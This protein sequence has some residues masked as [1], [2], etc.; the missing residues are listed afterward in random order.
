L[1]LIYKSPSF[2]HA[3]LKILHGSSLKKRYELIAR[4]IGEKK[5]VFE[6]GCGT[7]LI[8]PY[9]QAGCVYE[10][11]DLNEHFINYNTKR[12]RRV[13]QKNMFDF[14][15]YPPNDVILLCDILHHVVPRHEELIR[16]V[17]KKTKKLIISEP[18]TSFKLLK[19]FKRTAYFLHK[20]LLDDDGINPFDNM[21]EWD[22]PEEKLRSLFN[23]CGCTKII[24]MGWNLV[25]VF[26]ENQHHLITKAIG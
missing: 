14:N 26:D 23:A 17:V 16:M 22:Y 6:P 11:W 12:G 1:S 25:A 18:P 24:K 10:G 4:E 2:Y 19:K 20:T 7:C 3:F 15:D 8:Y 9:L 13:Y 21:V 5:R